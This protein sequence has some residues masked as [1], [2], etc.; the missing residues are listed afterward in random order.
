MQPRE[1]LQ[2]VQEVHKDRL[3]IRPSTACQKSFPWAGAARHDFV[4]NQYEF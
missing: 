2:E 4:S 3:Q 1:A